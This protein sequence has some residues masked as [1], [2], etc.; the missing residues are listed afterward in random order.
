LKTL[1]WHLETGITQ[2]VSDY[3]TDLRRNSS[4]ILDRKKFSTLWTSKHR[5][6]K[7]NKLETHKL[8]YT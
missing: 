6:Y 5:L 1:P 7:L 3:A 8:H 2:S 4:P